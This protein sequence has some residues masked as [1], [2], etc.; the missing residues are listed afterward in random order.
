MCKVSRKT[1]SIITLKQPFNLSSS[2]SSNIVTKVWRNVYWKKCAKYDKNTEKVRHWVYHIR[3]SKV[4]ER[5]SIISPHDCSLKHHSLLF[6]IL[7]SWRR[8]RRWTWRSTIIRSLTC[9]CPLTSAWPGTEWKP[10]LSSRGSAASGIRS[11]RTI[12]IRWAPHNTLCSDVGYG[13]TRFYLALDQVG[14]Q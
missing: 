1:A 9:C 11:T 14:A 4:C 13:R 3:R 5:H 10:S 7:C 6:Q 8:G 2:M 12:S